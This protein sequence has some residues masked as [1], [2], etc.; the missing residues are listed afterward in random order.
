MEESINQYDKSLSATKLMARSGDIRGLLTKDGWILFRVMMAE[1]TFYDP[2]DFTTQFA[3]YGSA[4]SGQTALRIQDSNSKEVLYH[5]MKGLLIEAFQGYSEPYPEVH[6]FFNGSRFGRLQKD[7]GDPL[8]QAT[9]ADVFGFSLKG[10]D[11]LYGKETGYSRF[12]I[13]AYQYTSFD[14]IN[15]STKAF[16]LRS[17]YPLNKL[18]VE[19]LDPNDP[20]D[21]KFM[22]QVLRGIERENVWL[23]SPG[24]EGYPWSHSSIDEIVGV[25]PMSWNGKVAKVGET[26]VWK[27][28]GGK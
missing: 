15:P 10:A 8:V 3:A 18:K 1:L 26:P 17:R 22:I 7:L 2:Y 27:A 19:P 6:Q 12:L 9:A 20:E 23:W 16:Y 4:N 13:P 11:S 25:P 14:I 24:V 5:E 21:L 28:G